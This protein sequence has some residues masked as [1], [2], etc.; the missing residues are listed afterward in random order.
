MMPK[1]V[2]KPHNTHIL[3]T[4]PVRQKQ[5]KTLEEYQYGTSQRPS[6]C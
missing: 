4:I 2:N 3:E 5:R 6:E 1:I